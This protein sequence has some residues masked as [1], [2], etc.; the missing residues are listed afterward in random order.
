LITKAKIPVAG[1]NIGPVHKKDVV[2]A[3]VMLEKDPTFACILAFDVKVEREAQEHADKSGVK[4]FSA[5][6]IYHLEAKFDKYMA[7][8]LAEK[9]RKVAGEA[10]FPCM[11]R[12]HQDSVFNKR[13]P[14]IF[15]VRVVEGTLR[16]QTP[17]VIPS[18]EFIELGRVASIEENHK[19]LEVATK[20]S[21]VAIKIDSSSNNYTYGRH[22][23][24]KDELYSK[25]SRSSIDCLKK[26]FGESISK[27]DRILIQK[28]K[29]IFK[30]L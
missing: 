18:K 17:I 5:D 16:L 21:D 27:E 25:I 4:I 8:V 28:Y 19:P 7:E 3:S 13:D 26:N 12:I 24:Y 20:G 1:V 23:D 9:Q 6:I 30:I 29:G 11:L 10:V 15:G 14:L 22:F 2:R